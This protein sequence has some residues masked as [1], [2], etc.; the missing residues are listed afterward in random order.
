[1]TA[2]RSEFRVLDAHTYDRRSPGRWVWSHIRR[3]WPGVV[4]FYFGYTLDWAA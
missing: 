1:M 3:T 2:L 4:V